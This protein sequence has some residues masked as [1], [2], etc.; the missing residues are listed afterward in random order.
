MENAHLT[1][2]LLFFALPGAKWN[3]K[4]CKW[5]DPWTICCCTFPTYV[6]PW[7]HTGCIE[8]ID[9]R[10]SIVS[11]K[12][13]SFL[14]T[15]LRIIEGSLGALRIITG[16]LKTILGIIKDSLGAWLWM[17]LIWREGRQLPDSPH[18]CETSVR[19]EKTSSQAPRCASWKADKLTS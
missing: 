8:W 19:P 15:N 2:R 16:C 4:T 11:Y 3:C 1:W 13:T 12:F 17:Q 10:C 5:H 18:S 9:S 6:Q 14:K 7:I